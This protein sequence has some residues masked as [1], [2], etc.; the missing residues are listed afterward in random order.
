MSRKIV[1]ASYPKK[2]IQ[3][4]GWG[5]KKKLVILIWLQFAPKTFF[6]PFLETSTFQKRKEI[7]CF[8]FLK[9]EINPND[10][11]FQAEIHHAPKSNDRNIR[12]SPHRSQL[13][14][15]ST[16]LSLRSASGCQRILIATFLQS[17]EF[18]L[19]FKPRAVII[20]N[21][22]MV[23][24]AIQNPIQMCKILQKKLNYLLFILL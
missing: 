6:F 15:A 10:M 1:E 14:L 24:L 5:R 18:F 17:L 2:E 20:N 13:Q 19:K 11:C 9:R 4:L 8:R 22:W 7:Q 3:S 21:I 23:L 12:Y 16:R